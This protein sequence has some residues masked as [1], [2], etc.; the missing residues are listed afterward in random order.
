MKSTSE[1]IIKLIEKNKGIKLACTMAE[2]L[3]DHY[4]SSGNILD[5]RKI[6]N[7]KQ[8]YKARLYAYDKLI[9]LRG[10]VNAFNANCKNIYEMAEYLDVTPKFLADSIECYR[11]KYGLSLDNYGISFDEEYKKVING[12]GFGVYMDI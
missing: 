9:G 6:N 4:K 1:N 5:D 12:I 2:E 11:S 10:L 7:R 3:G 8:E